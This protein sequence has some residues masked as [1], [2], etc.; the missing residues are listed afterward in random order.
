MYAFIQDDNTIHFRIEGDPDGPGGSGSEL[1]IAVSTQTVTDNTWHIIGL[2]WSVTEDKIGIK[3]DGNAWE[4]DVDADTVT[5]FWSE[6]VNL[7]LGTPSRAVD[8]NIHI[9]E[10]SIHTTYNQARP[11]WSP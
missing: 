4:D 9:D 5:D 10:F 3:I 2:R 8:N 1:V 6:P 11:T 7:Y